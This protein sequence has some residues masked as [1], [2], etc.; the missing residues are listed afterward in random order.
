MPPGTKDIVPGNVPFTA[1]HLLNHNNAS[2]WQKIRFCP[3]CLLRQFMYDTKHVSKNK[4]KQN[5]YLKQANQ[6]SFTELKTSKP[7]G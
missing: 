1:Y 2:D 6:V 3:S 7:L 4:K 5:Q